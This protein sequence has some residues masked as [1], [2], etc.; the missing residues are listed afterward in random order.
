MFL[1]KCNLPADQVNHNIIEILK[2]FF[3]RS[4]VEIFIFYKLFIYSQ[5]VEYK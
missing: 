3:K 5:R 4:L 1:R 2:N